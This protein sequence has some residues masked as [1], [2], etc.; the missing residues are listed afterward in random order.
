M[1]SKWKKDLIVQINHYQDYFLLKKACLFVIMLTNLKLQ[2]VHKL[3]VVK[4]QKK[5][6]HNLPLQLFL[7]MKKRK[8]KMILNY[9]LQI[10]T[11]QRLIY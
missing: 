5:L 6:R 11:D 1:Q 9:K 2:E 4:Q 8:M 10:N 7:T 3:P